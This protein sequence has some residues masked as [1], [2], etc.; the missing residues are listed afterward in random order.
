MQISFSV[1]ETRPAEERYLWWLCGWGPPCHK[2]G[3]AI[4]AT[5]LS[6]T[7]G[8]ITT[9]QLAIGIGIGV[10]LVV[11]ALAL[12]AFLIRRKRKGK[13]T[14][15]PS[16]E[17]TESQERFIYHNRQQEELAG[18][19]VGQE[20]PAPNSRDL[21]AESQSFT[22]ARMIWH[23]STPSYLGPRVLFHDR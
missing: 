12:I 21:H 16:S 22:A 20:M 8:G 2:V 18:D 3:P 14:P 9:T 10:P 11:F 17:A 7:H 5:I 23:I 15:T 6:N 1:R 19:I 4:T 13:S